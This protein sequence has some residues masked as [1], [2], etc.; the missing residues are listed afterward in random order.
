MYL[1]YDIKV[2]QVLGLMVIQD[3]Y[4]VQHKLEAY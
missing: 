4:K 3:Q 2:G 1:K